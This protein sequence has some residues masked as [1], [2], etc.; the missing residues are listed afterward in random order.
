MFPRSGQQV[1]IT[2]GRLCK[3]KM[4][5]AQQKLA[6]LSGTSERKLKAVR[7]V[8]RLPT[9]STEHTGEFDDAWLDSCTKAKYRKEHHLKVR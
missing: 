1:A 3:K 8:D 6:Q 2:L 5:Q 7:K 4:E 9:R